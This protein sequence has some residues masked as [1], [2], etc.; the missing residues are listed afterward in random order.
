[1]LDFL[2]S[3]QFQS[4]QFYPTASV[5]SRMERMGRMRSVPSTTVAP[6]ADAKRIAV[7]HAGALAP[8]MN[9]LARVAAER[10]AEATRKNDF[11][12]GATD[13]KL[14][15]SFGVSEWDG[16]QTVSEFLDQTERALDQARVRGPSSI[17]YL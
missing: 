5:V 7:M 17:V 14:A 8:G 12:Y 10:I 6:S 15:I 13:V 3:P 9:Q 4:K 2:Q 1:M 16:Q 11:K